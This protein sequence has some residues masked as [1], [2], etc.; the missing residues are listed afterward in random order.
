[1][2]SIASRY[3]LA[4]YKLAEEKNE[5]SLYLDRFDAFLSILES[6]PDFIHALKNAFY[7]KEEKT[8][9]IRKV[10]P[11]DTFGLLGSFVLLLM[12]NHRIQ[13]LQAILIEAKALCQQATDIQHGVVYSTTP[14]SVE[15]LHTISKA[16]QAQTTKTLTLVNEID[17]SLI[18]GIKVEIGGKVYDSS[19]LA[20]VNA[21]KQ[22]LLK[23]GS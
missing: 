23:R 12:K 17:P 14:L 18:G 20:Q 16:M 13:F 2:D 6:T 10:L 3:G 21:L 7:S 15:Q 9:L 11:E 4:L 19:L 22:R 5:F 1:M 8:L